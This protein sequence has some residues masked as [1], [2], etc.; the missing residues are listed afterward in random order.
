V[1]IYLDNA[2]TTPMH[3]KVL[4]TM[5]PYF[6]ASFANA[7]SLHTSG[8]AA[9]QA[10][11]QA[12]SMTARAIGAAASEI[13]FTSGGTEAD[14][15]ALVG[16][17]L[18]NQNKGKHIITSQIEH[19]AVLHTC[20]YLEKLGFTVTYLPVDPMGCVDVGSLEKAIRPDTVLVSIMMANNEVGTIQPIA[21]IGKLCEEHGI[22][23]HTDAVQAV[24]VLPIDVKKMGIGMLS[25]SAHKFHG[26]KGV[27]A[28]Y[29][30]AGLRVDAYLHGG[31]QERARR[32]GTYNTPGIVGMGKALEMAASGMQ[33]N[34]RYVAALRD[35]LIHGLLAQIPDIRING[36][37]EQRLPGNVSISFLHTSGESVLLQLDLMGIDASGGAACAS[38]SMDPSHVLLAMGADVAQAQ[39][40]L[41][42]SIAEQNTQEEID[43]VIRQLPPLIARMRSKSAAWEQRLSDK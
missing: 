33:E 25:M 15:W 41:R 13:Y 12:R 5:Q 7:S 3:A 26:P 38:G 4:E 9:R 23:F 34:A 42:F 19:H 27:G 35:R 31:A 2:A 29:I 16:F 32:S 24:G 40:T 39:S 43:A 37:L 17:A 30:R 21:Q 8:R 36:H 11:E 14:N 10:V 1:R 28:L 18:A 20:A 6:D 22:A